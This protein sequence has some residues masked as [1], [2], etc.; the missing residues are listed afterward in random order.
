MDDA[1]RASALALFIVVVTLTAACSSPTHR[2]KDGDGATSP[3]PARPSAGSGPRFAAGGP[4]ADDYGAT[5]GYPVKAIYRDRFFVGLFSHYD[6][7]FES[8]VVPRAVVPSP[9]NRALPEPPVRYEYQGKAHTLDDY[10]AR[11]PATGL[12]VAG[13]RAR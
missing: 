10:L 2:G 8:R 13:L 7:I 11:N 3:L 4:D 9:L 1:R 12:L 6:Q 5:D